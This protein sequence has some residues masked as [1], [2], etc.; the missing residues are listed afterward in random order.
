LIWSAILEAFAEMRRNLLRTVL[1]VCGVLIA[2]SSVVGIASMLGSVQKLIR[3]ILSESSGVRTVTV[4]YKERKLVKGRWVAARRVNPLSIADSLEIRNRLGDEIDAVTAAVVFP[5]V[6]TLHDNGW[7]CQIHGVEPDYFRVFNRRLIE[8]RTIAAPDLGEAALVAVV[9]Q[10][11]ATTFFGTEA[12]I[13]GEVRIN[14]VRTQVVGVIADTALAQG[15]QI[16]LYIP[17]TAALFRVPVASA[18]GQSKVIYVQVRDGVD[19]RSFRQRLLETAVSRHDGY[20]A[21]DFDVQ[22]ADQSQREIEQGMYLIGF[23]FLLISGL[24]LITGGVGIMNVLLAAVAERTREVGVRRAVG[25]TSRDIL[26]QF[27]VESLCLTGVG[28][29]GGIGLGYL[30]GFV[31]SWVVNKFMAIG[32]SYAY[33]LRPSLNPFVLILAVATSTMVGIVFGMYPALRASQLDPVE[34]LRHE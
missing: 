30:V 4:A 7:Q 14:D 21:E 1:T 24:G 26:I 16:E 11:T 20:S 23:V 13:T 19:L 22:S 33:G 6:V 29:A 27:L 9:S 28:G 25:A 32:S 34:A 3:H 2:I 5:G 15:R 12:P 18:R 8:G 17:F 31:L 10:Y